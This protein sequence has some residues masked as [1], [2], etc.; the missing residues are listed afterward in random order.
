MNTKILRD[1]RSLNVKQ[2]MDKYHNDNSAYSRAIYFAKLLEID[3]VA[4]LIE[5]KDHY[6]LLLDFGRTRVRFEGDQRII[7]VLR[8][9]NKNYGK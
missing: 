4:A 2:A 9:I 6:E 7:E 5:L 1:L 8:I 3:T